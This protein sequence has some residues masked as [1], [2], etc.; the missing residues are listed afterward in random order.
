MLAT[1]TEVL[2]KF[3]RALIRERSEQEQFVDVL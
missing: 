1:L 3:Q 2:A